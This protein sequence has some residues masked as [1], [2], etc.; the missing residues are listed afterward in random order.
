MT[1]VIQARLQGFCVAVGF[2]VVLVGPVR[3]ERV[4]TPGTLDPRI[5][6]VPYEA[7]QVVRLQGRVGYALELQFESG[8]TFVGLASGDLTGV[9]FTAQGE[10]LFLK[11][12]TAAITTNL[13]VLTDRR[14]YRFQYSV[15]PSPA[16]LRTAR[17]KIFCAGDGR[18]LLCGRPLR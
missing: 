17:L 12:K 10:H 5:R 7:D 14:V 11:P 6:A 13:T 15:G 4:P 16:V 9:D 1:G 2:G 3:A 8:E 18:R